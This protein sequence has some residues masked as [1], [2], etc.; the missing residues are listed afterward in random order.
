MINLNVLF[1]SYQI[2]RRL[3]TIF[4]CTTVTSIFLYEFKETSD[5]TKADAQILR[6]SI[7]ELSQKLTKI[8][9]KNHPAAQ[10][11][12]SW[13]LH[14]ITFP[15]VGVHLP[16]FLPFTLCFT[17]DWEA[18]N[19]LMGLTCLDHI[20]KYYN[21]MLLRNY[22]RKSLDFFLSIKIYRLFSS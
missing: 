13:I 15:H 1:C 3:K 12:F 4:T 14:Q 22:Q 17:D 21:Y 10:Y 5:V 19:K 11:C 18:T 20:S 9:W 7:K 2:L 6:L 16:D 8:C